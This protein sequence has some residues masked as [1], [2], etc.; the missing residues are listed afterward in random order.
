MIKK[1]NSQHKKMNMPEGL[2]GL[3]RAAQQDSSVKPTTEQQVEK[4]ETVAPVVDNSAEIEARRQAEEASRREAAELAARQKAAEE[5][6]RAALEAEKAA[7][8]ARKKAAELSKPVIS[9][10]PVSL[11]NIESSESWKLFKNYVE[12][13]KLDTSKGKEIWINADLRYELDKMKTAS[14]SS[15]KL[16]TMVNAILHTFMD[17]HRKEIEDLLAQ[18]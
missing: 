13:Y 1:T 11:D 3:V 12:Q 6:A 2:A 18:R 17:L 5:A 16:K 14:R 10:T 15:M 9:Q 4:V 7:E 8:A